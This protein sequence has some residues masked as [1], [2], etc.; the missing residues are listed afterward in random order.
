KTVAAY[1]GA[2]DNTGDVEKGLL[3]FGRHCAA[4]HQIGGEYGTDYGP[5]LATI[6]NRK[7]DAILKDILD[8]NLSIADGYDLWELTM[9]D[10]EVRWGIIGSETPNSIMLKVYNKEDEVISRKAH[11]SMKS[12]AMSLMPSGLEHQ[13][14]PGEMND[15]LTFI[16]KL[17]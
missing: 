13:I 11:A 5:D 2:L 4:C 17:K 10:G 16:K 15:L 8:P 3:S 7:P 12:L 6:R 1:E 9:N 14:T